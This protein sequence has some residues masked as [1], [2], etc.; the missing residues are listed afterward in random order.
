MHTDDEPYC[1]DPFCDCH[2]DVEYHD[3]VTRF[4]PERVNEDDL[5]LSLSLFQILGE[6]G[7][8]A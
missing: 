5:A 8:A 3:L 2:F 7:Q 4:D 6:E 1:D